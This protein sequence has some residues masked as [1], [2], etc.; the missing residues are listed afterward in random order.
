MSATN[1]LPVI[2]AALR[3][4]ELPQF[5]DW[6]TADQRD[7]EIQDPCYPGY[8]DGDWQKDAQECR[9]LLE[10]SG[11][12]GRC[13]IHAVYSGVDLSTWDEKIR[14]VISER[15]RESLQ[16]GA[17]IGATHAVIHSPFL[18]FGSP[19]VYFSAESVRNMIG[20]FVHAVIDPLLPTAEQ[21]N[22]ALVIETI[23]DGNSHALIELVQSFNSPYVRLSVDTGH[24]KIMERMGGAPPDQWVI[25]AAHLLGHVHLQDTDGHSDR[26]W[27]IGDGNI[28]WR[29]FFK[30]LSMTDANPRLILE[31]LDTNDIMPS[32]HWLTAQGLAR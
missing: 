16:F 2:G 31:L 3:V 6:L 28:N 22:C 13:G 9:A 18:W 30:A 17:E 11:Y 29:S 23:A 21:M 4:K 20:S 12:Q 15:L 25:D 26:H 27:G 24:V 8:L 1:T 5:I 19:L 14:A 32:M 7:L 10:A